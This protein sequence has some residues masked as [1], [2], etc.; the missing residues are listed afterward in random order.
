MTEDRIEE[1]LERPYWL[2]DIVSKRIPADK[3]EEYA[4]LQEYCEKH[5]EDIRE[6]F[7]FFLLKLN[8]YHDLKIS[9]DLGETFSPFDCEPVKTVPSEIYLYIDDTSL[10]TYDT[11]D[12]YM[13]LY[14]PKDELLEDVRTLAASVG[15]FVWK[16]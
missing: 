13:T 12:T 14:D 3:S 16:G 5:G 11:E 4:L 15:L 6:R 2:I 9:W 7:V 10:L 8:C 1:L